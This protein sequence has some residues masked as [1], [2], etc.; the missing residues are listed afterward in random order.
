MKFKYM[1]DLHGTVSFIPNVPQ[2][3]T[4]LLLAG[5]I[6]EASKKNQYETLIMY[7]CSIFKEVVLICGNHEYYGKNIISIEKYLNEL[8]N[9]IDNFTFLANSS[10]VIDD[11]AIVGST[12]WT[13][14]DNNN[15]VLKYDAKMY[16][17]DYSSIRCGDSV[18]PWQRPLSP[19]I[20][21]GIHLDS[22]KFIQNELDKL[23]DLGYDKRIVMTHHAPSWQS[24]HS[25]YVGDKFNGCFVSDMDDFIINT[26]PDIWIHGHVHNSFDYNIGNTRILCNPRGYEHRYTA[27]YENQN[28][29]QNL[30]FEL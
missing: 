8:S 7:V 24:V 4:V 14:F 2:K 1:S 23:K 17:N 9:K 10:T 28:F 22:K 3:D 25:S 13:D 18:T 27:K 26:N 29:N 5:D 19:D 12:L 30:V 15:P 6:H 20:V 21:Y 16:M 11:V